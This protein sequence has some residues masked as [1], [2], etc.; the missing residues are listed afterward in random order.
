[1]EAKPDLT[2]Q[3]KNCGMNGKVRILQRLWLNLET[4]YCEEV[5]GDEVQLW[6]K[7]G[8]KDEPNDVQAWLVKT[9]NSNLKNLKS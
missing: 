4:K 3:T 5:I 1:M 2:K 7:T 6:T 8:D 9:L